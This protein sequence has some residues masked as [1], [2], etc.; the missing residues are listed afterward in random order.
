MAGTFVFVHGTGVRQRGIDA[1]V[2]AIEEGL[3]KVGIA[4]TVTAPPWGPKLG[5]R[6]QLIDATLPSVSTRAATDAP[7]A[8]E[9]TVAM[10][11]ILGED[12]LAEL[13]IAGLGAQGE[14]AAGGVVVGEQ[15]PDQI[16]VTAMDAMASR[17]PDLSYAGISSDDAQT[18]IGNV[19]ASAEVGEAAMA[20]GDPLDSSLTEAVA[21]AVVADLISRH[22]TDPIG[23][24]PV[25]VLSGAVR[26]RLVDDMAKALI[27]DG[28]RSFAPVD[29]VKKRFVR[30][31]NQK[32]S[33]FVVGRRHSIMS[34]ANATV[35]D[36]LFY[37]QRG[38]VIRS[39]VAEQM[40]GL[41]GPVVAV[42][43]S[44]GGIVLVDLLSGPEAPQVD[45][46][47][48]AG[49]Q[50]PLFYAIDS[51]A[52]LRPGG[53]GEPFRP[54]LNI[55]NPNDILSF[56][57]TGVFDGQA[58]IWDVG[59]DPGVPFPESHSAYWHDDHTYQAIKER[60]PDA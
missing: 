18:S 33:D 34:M 20:A 32:A 28:T 56:R 53:S 22:R 11:A 6:N 23:T 2:A 59:T 9:E 14:A 41:E 48:T 39:Y 5:V 10:W 60:W 15:R 36:I 12:P 29:W 1:S 35:G 8:E 4:A 47:V 19:R 44:L 55:Y 31:A 13:R 46:L 58:D 42:G 16:I 17:L 30:F 27:G 51:L 54:W 52:H 45:L 40:A 43:H 24:E 38:E 7:S 57:A 49:S 26:D 50:S 37:Q 3:A 21:R 25:L